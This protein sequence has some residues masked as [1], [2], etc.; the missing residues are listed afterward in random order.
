[1]ARSTLQIPP[2][3]LTLHFVRVVRAMVRVHEYPG[4]LNTSWKQ[5]PALCLRQAL[6]I[7]AGSR[8]FLIER[9]LYT[10]GNRPSIMSGN[11]L[12][13]TVIGQSDHG[14]VE[15]AERGERVVPWRL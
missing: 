8:I 3:P 13:A 2:S 12:D 7:P 14:A 9:T 1:M 11:V 10:K 4:K 6:Q 5:P 15:H